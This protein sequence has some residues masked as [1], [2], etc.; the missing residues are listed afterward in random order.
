VYLAVNSSLS[1]KLQSK[2]KFPKF[3]KELLSCPVCIGFWI[4]TGLSLRDPVAAL[5]IAFTGGVAYEVKQKFLPCTQ[6]TSKVNV[7]EWNIK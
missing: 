2:F 4:A 3:L 7:S 1:L 6:C 5:A